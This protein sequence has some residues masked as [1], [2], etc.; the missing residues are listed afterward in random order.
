MLLSS[1]TH[2][3]LSATVIALMSVLSG[4][5]DNADL[6]AQVSRPET[7][8]VLYETGTK[9]GVFEDWSLSSTP[10]WQ[11]LKG[12]LLNDGT[13]GGAG[14]APIFAPYRPTSAD[15]AVEAEIRVIREGNSFGVVVRAD[16]QPDGR[17]VGY[18]VGMG[19]NLA[20]PVQRSTTIC[21]LNGVMSPF[22]RNDCIGEG[23]IFPPGTDWH[24][25]R[26]EANGN[27]IRLLID[28]K[29][30]INMRD[31]RFLSAGRVGL[32]SSE[33]QL[34]VRNFKVIALN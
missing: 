19:Q 6:A 4:S 17:K 1:A 24:I 34:E 9:R 28:K 25:Y 20:R 7:A 13:R 27:E 26:I 11:R 30:I 10:D 12:M 21:Y 23:E 3:R 16:I 2:T 15:Y 18:A 14:F 32:W 31:N 5:V 8:N 22:I 29:V 33:Y